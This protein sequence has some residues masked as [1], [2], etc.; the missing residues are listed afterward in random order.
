MGEQI[1]MMQM[2]CKWTGKT[3]NVHY[4]SDSNDRSVLESCLM[5]DEYNFAKLL[6]VRNVERDGRGVAIDI[7]AHIGGATLALISAGY[8]VVAVEPL[9]P[10]IEV[11]RL[12][13]ES[14]GM[15]D[16]CR[17]LSQPFGERNGSVVVSWGEP[18]WAGDKSLHHHRYIGGTGHTD[19]RA[20]N[21]TMDTISLSEITARYNH[22]D[23]VKTDCEGG[24][25]TG[26]R[27]PEQPFTELD[28]VDLIVGEL[29][30]GRSSSDFMGILG[31]QFKDITSEF[32]VDQVTHIVARRIAEECKPI[33]STRKRPTSKR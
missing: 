25:Y 23:I 4:R 12:N 22:I 32:P 3:L 16:R 20:H 27:L 6:P 9:P 7:G 30:H 29:H 19:S 33:P 5:M 24:E 11:M 18:T 31:P 13:L 28:K 26:F 10:N 21:I 8:D 1:I 14:N 2:E 15:V 17:I